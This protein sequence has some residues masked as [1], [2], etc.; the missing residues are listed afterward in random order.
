MIDF[1]A[2]TPVSSLIGGVMIGIASSLLILVN[3]KI[4]GISGILGGVLK[5]KSNDMHWRI[6]FL[7]GLIISP[8]VYAMFFPLPPIN[9]SSNHALTIVAGLLVGMG[10]RYG[11]GC[12]SGHGVCGLARLSLRSLIATSVFILTGIITVYITHHLL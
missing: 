7:L 3:G 4:A 10:T 12:T 11:S 6:L 2:A 5:L 9:I 1:A 8:Y